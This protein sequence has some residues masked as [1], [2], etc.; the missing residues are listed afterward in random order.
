ML[1]CPVPYTAKIHTKPLVRAATQPST[2]HSVLSSR[3][4]PGLQKQTSRVD[5][6]KFQVF[7]LGFG[8]RHAK[9]TCTEE[10]QSRSLI[11]NCTS[12]A[13]A[14]YSRMLQVGGGRS[15]FAA[16]SSYCEASG[17][18]VLCERMAGSLGTGHKIRRTA[19]WVVVA[20]PSSNPSCERKVTFNL[21][22]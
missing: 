20:Y 8:A 9:T 14:T 2:V 11:S 1:Q 19:T 13:A 18:V 22:G 15:P 5:L 7:S 6:W 3:D 16:F 10:L 21:Q 12:V 4:G 17:M